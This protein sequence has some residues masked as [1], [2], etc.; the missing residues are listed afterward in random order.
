MRAC[1][2]IFGLIVAMSMAAACT[3][4]MPAQEMDRGAAGSSPKETLPAKAPSTQVPQATSTPTRE[5]S[6]RMPVVPAGAETLVDLARADLAQKLGEKAEGIALLSVEGTE[7]PDTSLGVPEPD[8]MYAQVIT[9]G[10]VI[11]LG[12]GDGA[13]AKVYTYHG[14]G[15]RVVLASEDATSSEP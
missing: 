7:F 3:T 8:R 13:R 2:I 1:L 5:P 14:S 9:P 10:Y 6:T 11:R 4:P 12:V 15:D